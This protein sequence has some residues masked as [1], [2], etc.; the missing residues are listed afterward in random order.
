MEENFGRST[1]SKDS[2]GIFLNWNLERRCYNK[3]E[4]VVYCSESKGQSFIPFRTIPINRVNKQKKC[5]SLE[6]IHQH[7]TVNSESQF[8]IYLLFKTYLKTHYHFVKQ[9]SW[10]FANLWCLI[11]DLLTPKISLESLS[12]CSNKP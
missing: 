2:K 6:W 3:A 4:K 12:A 7:T 9:K 5:R 1:I 10:S 11:L 8:R